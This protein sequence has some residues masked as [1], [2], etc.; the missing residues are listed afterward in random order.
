MVKKVMELKEIINEYEAN[1]LDL[2]DTNKK[3]DFDDKVDML[4][5][6]LIT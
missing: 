2:I 6:N 5:V 3:E 1:H 4:D